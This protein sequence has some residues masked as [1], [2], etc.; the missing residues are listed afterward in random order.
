MKSLKRKVCP[1][2]YEVNPRWDQR[3]EAWITRW[4]RSWGNFKLSKIRRRV[5]K[6]IKELE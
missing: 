3:D 4:W 1:Y 5:L 2:L 6:K